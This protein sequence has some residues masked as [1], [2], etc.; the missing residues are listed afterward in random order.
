MAERDGERGN[1]VGVVDQAV[2]FLPL[3]LGLFDRVADHDE[4][5]R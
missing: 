5:C 3:R 1:G 4:T 2:E